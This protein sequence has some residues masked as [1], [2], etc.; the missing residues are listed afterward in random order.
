MFRISYYQF[1]YKYIPKIIIRQL[2]IN[3]AQN[4]NCFPSKGGVLDHYIPHMILS[5]RNWDH[6]KH[7]WVEFGASVHISQFN[8]PKNKNRPITLD[9]IYLCPVPNLQ[10]G[11]QIIDLRTGQFITRSK[12]FEIPITYFVIKSFE[13][14]WR[15]RYLIH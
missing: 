10:G 13:K 3:V 15:S 7:Y 12:V 6:T 14:W 8:Y 9:G 5:Q 2:P 11:Y 1:P 4:L